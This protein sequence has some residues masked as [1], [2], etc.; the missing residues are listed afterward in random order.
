MP[1]LSNKS[2]A[3]LMNYWLEECKKHNNC[4]SCCNHLIYCNEA[5]DAIIKEL[6]GREEE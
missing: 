2:I 4:E 6:L 5:S 1:P 3:K